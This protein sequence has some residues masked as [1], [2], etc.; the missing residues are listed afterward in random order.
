[1]L[2]KLLKSLF[3]GVPTGMLV[4]VA[5]FLAILV[6]A[7]VLVLIGQRDLAWVV[8]NLGSLVWVLAILAWIVFVDSR[9]R[10]PGLS[11]F[12]RYARIVTFYR[13]P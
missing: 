13:D 10:W 3:Q 5:G 6:S 8:G 11:A 2:L 12:R 4:E 7:I 9:R 1:M